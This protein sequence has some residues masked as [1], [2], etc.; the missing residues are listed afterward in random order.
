MWKRFQMPDPHEARLVRLAPRCREG[1]E[2]DPCELA[3]FFLVGPTESGKRVQGDHWSSFVPHN[4]PR[5]QSKWRE[6]WSEWQDLNVRPPRPERGALPDG[7]TLQGCGPSP[8][9]PKYMDHLGAII[10][11]SQ[12]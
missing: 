5:T 7:A 9:Q 6:T 10:A 3:Q 11:L 4:W 2:L 12:F 1:F 8:T